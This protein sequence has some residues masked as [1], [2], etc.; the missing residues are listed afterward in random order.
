MAKII[1]PTHVDVADHYYKDAVD[2][3]HRFILCWESER[4]NFQA[5]K[6]KRFKAFID[7]RMA[8]ECS[9]K[10]ICSYKIHHE[11]SG[12]ELVGRMRKYSHFIAR[13]AA[14]IFELLSVDVAAWLKITAKLCDENL[15]VDIRYRFDAFDFR[16][17]DEELYYQTIGDDFWLITFYEKTK[18]FTSYIGGELSKESRVISSA[19]LR[20]LMMAE[21]MAYSPYRSKSDR[22]DK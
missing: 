21:I 6:S 9:L 15:P 20:E 4:Y 14:D 11:L 17:N 10:S 13:S 3:L 5:V 7:L 1:K 12:E 18:E 19:D 16:S 8:L 2:F 22:R